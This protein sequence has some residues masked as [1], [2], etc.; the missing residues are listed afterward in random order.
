[1]AASFAST[2]ARI[3]TMLGWLRQ[4]SSVMGWGDEVVPAETG[5]VAANA[6]PLR[7]TQT[8][9]RRCSALIVLSQCY[10]IVPQTLLVSHASLLSQL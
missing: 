5:G 6:T 8:T 4:L 2:R 1:M 7:V 3:A 10:L 9:E